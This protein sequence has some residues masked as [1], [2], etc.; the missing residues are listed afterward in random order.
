ME[1]VDFLA[2]TKIRLEFLIFFLCDGI[3]GMRGSVAMCFDAQIESSTVRVDCVSLTYGIFVSS[4]S[5]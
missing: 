2:R 3:Q 4:A 5:S 1:F